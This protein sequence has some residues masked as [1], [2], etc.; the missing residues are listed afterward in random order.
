MHSVA[1]AAHATPSPEL[2]SI[3]RLRWSRLHQATL[4]FMEMHSIWLLR[5]TAHWM[6]NIH[7]E[8]VYMLKSIHLCLCN[9]FA[10]V[11]DRVDPHCAEPW[12]WSLSLS[13][14]LFLSVCSRCHGDHLKGTLH[15]CQLWPSV[16]LKKKKKKTI[17]SGPRP[18][19]S[20]CVG[21][22]RL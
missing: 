10:K 11:T 19:S 16:P 15:C 1:E 8:S 9:L 12:R 21:W 4:V 14:S 18:G 3:W 20:S 5:R 7:G 17:V 2:S 6:W 22:S 13:P